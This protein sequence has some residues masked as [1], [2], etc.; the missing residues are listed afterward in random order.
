MSGEF[1]RKERRYGGGV[2]VE[3]DD[4]L[5]VSS[6][7]VS[8]FGW[9]FWDDEERDFSLQTSILNLLLLPISITVFSSGLFRY[10]CSIASFCNLNNSSLC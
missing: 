1:S 2:K 8:V 10:S 6:L 7:F 9:T 3:D 4:P 5:S